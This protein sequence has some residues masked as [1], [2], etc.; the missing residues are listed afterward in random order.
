MPKR[1]KVEGRLY[2]DACVLDESLYDDI[3]QETGKSQHIVIAV[4][5]H[6]ALGEALGNMLN[7]GGSDEVKLFID[8]LDKLQRSGRLEIVGNDEIDEVFE[9][10]NGCLRPNNFTDT[11]H[12]STAITHKC[13]NL[14]SSDRDIVGLDKKKK[15]RLKEVARDFSVDGFHITKRPRK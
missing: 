6:L 14:V 13:S 15:N 8:F 12:I 11:V 9:R 3:F 2:Y 10:I 4:I 5:S 7:D 1:K